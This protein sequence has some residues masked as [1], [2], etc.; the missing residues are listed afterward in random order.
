MWELRTY[1]TEETQMYGFPNRFDKVNEAG[2]LILPTSN[3]IG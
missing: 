2:A 3:N 1:H